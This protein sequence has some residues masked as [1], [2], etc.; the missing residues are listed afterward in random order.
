MMQKVRNEVHGARR[1]IALEFPFIP[2][3]EH[4]VP[5]GAC[6]ETVGRIRIEVAVGWNNKLG[7][8]WRQRHEMFDHL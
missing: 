5:R 2:V 4:R 8:V 1:F 7:I 3:V 6:P